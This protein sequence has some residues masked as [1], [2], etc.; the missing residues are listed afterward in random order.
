MTYKTVLNV[1][2]LS[3]REQSPNH[4]PAHATAWKSIR[5][6]MMNPASAKTTAFKS[7]CCCILDDPVPTWSQTMKNS[8]NNSKPSSA[9]IGGRNI[10]RNARIWPWRIS[11]TFSGAH[12]RSSNAVFRRAS[13]RHRHACDASNTF[14]TPLIASTSKINIHSDSTKPPTR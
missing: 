7:S 2:R 5:K 11:L 8:P 10:R 3:F 9:S 12:N 6:K 1:A 14:I 13:A 4:I